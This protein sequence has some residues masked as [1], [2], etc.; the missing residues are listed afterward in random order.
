MAISKEERH[1]IFAANAALNR[2]DERYNKRP[3]AGAFHQQRM[4]ATQPILT[5][6]IAILSLLI[7]GIVFIPAGA[8]MVWSSNSVVQAIFQY[9]DQC[10]EGSVCD[11]E[12]TLPRM[13]P[14]VYMYYRL[15]NFYQ[16]HRK[17][18][19]SR[20]ISQLA[21]KEASLENLN[22]C[23]PYNE[24]GFKAKDPNMYNLPCG[25][26]ALSVF[27]DTFVVR[28]SNSSQIIQLNKK[29][30]VWD[31]DRNM[32]KNPRKEV[33]HRVISDFTDVDFIKWMKPAP[34]P[35]FKKLYRIIE[36][37]LE[38][39]YTVQIAS[40]FPTKSISANKFV[41]FSTTTHIGGKNSFVGWA[42][43]VTGVVLIIQGLVFLLQQ[44]ICPRKMGDM[45][46]LEWNMSSR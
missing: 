1:R 31:V 20:D 17:F 43:V 18:V 15:S 25:L 14:P 40:N 39:N 19:S 33:G 34:L 35:D 27:N 2:S 13:E 5:P 23:E 7:I 21:G 9:D 4:R 22:L 44:K 38:G 26:M 12:V 46:Y 3:R 30:I 16:N 29:N 45:R 42:Y 32:F 37:P 10:P 36:E 8:L 11:M 28:A 41:V 24:A 6:R